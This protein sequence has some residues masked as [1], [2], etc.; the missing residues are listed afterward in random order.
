[1]LVKKA[2]GELVHP[3]KYEE[4]K[5]LKNAEKSKSNVKSCKDSNKKKSF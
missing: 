3:G 2:T 1:M 4:L 5:K